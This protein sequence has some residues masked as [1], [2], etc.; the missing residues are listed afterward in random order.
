MAGIDK[1]IIMG[2]LGKDPE[3][4]LRPE[5]SGRRQ[6]QRRH[7][8]AWKDKTSGEKKDR[9]SG[10]VSWPGT[11]SG[12]S[13]GNTFRGSQVYV[14]GKLQTHSYNDKEGVK[15]YVTGSSRRTC[16]SWGERGFLGSGSLRLPPCPPLTAGVG[17]PAGKMISRF[18]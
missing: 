17:P 14:E 6:V 15:R 18:D 8:Q 10:T 12:K 3:V 7:L 5:R 9:P 13:A 4:T 11:S 1:M 16:S 2:N